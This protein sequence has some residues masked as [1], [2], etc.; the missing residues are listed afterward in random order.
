MFHNPAFI[1]M[2]FVPCTIYHNPRPDL[3]FFCGYTFLPLPYKFTLGIL[4]IGLLSIKIW[5]I[6]TWKWKE[7]YGMV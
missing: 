7:G 4:L 6:G 1:F 3:L 2:R 5:Q